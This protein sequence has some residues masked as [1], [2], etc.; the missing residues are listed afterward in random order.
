MSPIRQRFVRPVGLP[1]VNGYSHAVVFDGRMI[2][3]S[4]QVPLTADGEPVG[5]D[6][7][8][9]QVRQVFDNLAGA[10]AAAGSGLDQIVKLTVFLTDLADLEVFRRVR[11]EYVSP[12]SPPASSLVQVSGLVHPAFRI[13]IEALAVG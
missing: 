8:E 10:L 9:A 13:E 6:D 7:P 2:V 3:V 12:E 4:G 5:K 1:P 11:D